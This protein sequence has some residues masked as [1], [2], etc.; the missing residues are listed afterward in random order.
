VK[1]KIFIALQYIVPHHLFSRLVGFLAETRFG[2]IKNTFITQFAKHFQVNMREAKIEDLSAFDNFNDFF[3]RELKDNARPIT[4]E[5][6]AIANPADGAVSQLGP[7]K[8]G[9]I[10]QAKGQS[11]GVVDL[12]GGDSQ[13]ALPFMNGDFSTIYLSPKDY[14]RLHMPLKGTLREMIYVPGDLFSVNPTTAQNVPSLFSRNE[15]VVAIFDTEAGPMAMV[16]VGAMIVASIETV[17]SGLVTPPKRELKTFDYTAAA[18]EP[19]VLE[20]GQEMGRFK[21]G[22]TVVLS[23]GTD[24]MNWAD[25]Y[26][27]GTPTRMGETL[28]FVNS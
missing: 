10:F 24:V 1:D 28:G 9:S 27:E 3:T 22:S 25:K 15:R 6:N 20:K 17:W 12:L 4:E 14:H 7:I 8:D 23:F 21:L 13:R 19:I 2:P 26:K 16:L 5:K 18:R 11:F